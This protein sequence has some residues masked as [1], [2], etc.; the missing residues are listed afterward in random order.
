[1]KAQEATI[2]RTLQPA[3]ILKVPI[4]QRTYSWTQER[5]LATFWAQIKEKADAV[6]AVDGEVLSHYFGAL[7]LVPSKAIHGELQ[8]YNIVDGQQRLTTIMLC[9]SA[10]RQLSE[11]NGFDRLMLDIDHCLFNEGQGASQVKLETNAK[12]REVFLD[13]LHLGKQGLRDKY[14]RLFQKNDALVKTRVKEVKPFAAYWYF[15]EEGERYITDAS[16][17]DTMLI[18]EKLRALV[19]ALKSH[20]KFIVITLDET[21]DAQVIFETLNTGGEP[22]AAMDLVRNSIFQRA[23]KEGPEIAY[24]VET[25]LNEFHEKFWDHEIKCKARDLI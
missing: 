10:L 7:L 18:E 2:E 11:L 12:D 22:L 16:M 23:T 4:Y 5:Q 25:C 20:F 9:L 8:T 19:E 14:Y 24:E 13:L 3:Q 17:E 21:D 1:M 6:R 15:L